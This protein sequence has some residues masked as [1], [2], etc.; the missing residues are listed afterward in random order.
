MVADKLVGQ[1]FATM[2]ELDFVLSGAEDS[3]IDELS[4]PT[5]DHCKWWFK[6]EESGLVG[7]VTNASGVALRRVS[8]HRPT[9]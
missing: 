3:W 2:G 7:G 9:P 4:A 8:A 1:S 6:I 5:C